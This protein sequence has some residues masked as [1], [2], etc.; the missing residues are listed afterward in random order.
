MDKSKLPLVTVITLTYNNFHHLQ[1]TIH[2]VCVQDYPN[3]EYF[4]FDDCSKE[5]PHKMVEDYIETNRKNIKNYKIHSNEV[6]LGTVRNLNSAYHLA[7]GEIIMP[8]SCGDVFFSKDV[9]RRVVDRFFATKCDMLA[10]TRILYKDN[11]IPTKL[12]PNCYVRSLIEKKNTSRE[13]YKAFISSHFYDMISG[14]NMYVRKEVVEKLGFFDES[15]DLWEDGPFLSKYLWSNKIDFAYDIVSIWYE[16]GGVSANSF[17]FLSP[18]MRSDVKKFVE[19]EML[20]H[21]EIFNAT[22]QRK[23]SYRSQRLLCGH[24]MRRFLLYGKYLPELVYYILLTRKLIKLSQHD[25]VEINEI[26]SSITNQ[27]IDQ[28]ANKQEI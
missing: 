1:E 7:Q 8:L 11:F 24:T 2:S 10:T 13:Q 19:K 17:D 28:S 16:D 18:R 23:I 6:N 26:F 15:Y 12:L 25:E 9:I 4:I 22:E 27:I 20:A 5:F 3:I 14:C 21:I